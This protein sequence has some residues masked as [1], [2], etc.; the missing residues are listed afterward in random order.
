M[1]SKIKD[2]DS[3]EFAIRHGLPGDLGGILDILN[4]YILHT[5]HTFDTEP[6]SIDD[7][8]DWMEQFSE[9]GPYQLLVAETGGQITAYAHSGP[10]KPKPGYRSSVET[11]VYVHPD[12]HGQGLG[13]QVYQTLLDRLPSTGLHRACGGIALPNPASIQLHETLGFVEVGTFHETGLKFGEYRDVAWYE[14]AL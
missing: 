10:F 8:Q 7:K 2:I 3:G 12:H 9:D 4:H 6:F 11:T 5:H 14:K 13:T 1:A